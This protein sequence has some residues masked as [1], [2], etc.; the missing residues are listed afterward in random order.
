MATDTL[1]SETFLTPETRGIPNALFIGIVLMLLTGASLGVSYHYYQ[2][3]N[4]WHTL[5]S[6]FLSLNLIVCF[7]EICLFLRGDYVQRRNV[8]WHERMEKEG[9]I[10]AVEFLSY[11][12]NLRNMFSVTFWSDIWATYSMYDGSYADKRT[13]GFNGDIGNGFLSL[14]PSLIIHVGMVVSIL[15]AQLVG[16]IGVMMFFTWAYTTVIYWI[17]FVNVGRH[18]LLSRKD[19]LIYIVGT[20]APWVIF[21]LIGLYVSINIV[22]DNNFTILGH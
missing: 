15:P 17:S 2:S 3:F 4:V 9:I 11:P 19:N 22:I 5:M 7:W 12:V 21:S 20:N 18:K 8:Y 6:F 14:I 10:P 13:Y 1:N 16:L